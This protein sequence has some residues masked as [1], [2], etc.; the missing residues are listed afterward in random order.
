MVKYKDKGPLDL[1]AGAGGLD[2]TW[3]QVGFCRRL[4]AA[5][6][7]DT[8]EGCC[9]LPRMWG[10]QGNGIRQSVSC[11]SKFVFCAPHLLP[12]SFSDLL[13]PACWP[14]GRGAEGCREGL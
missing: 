7:P 2:T 6:C 10:C 14:A 13:Q 8:P 1:V 4:A 3:A 12:S 5:A 9:M 11:P